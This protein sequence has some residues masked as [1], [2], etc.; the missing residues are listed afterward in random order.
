MPGIP[1]IAQVKSVAQMTA[2]G[3]GFNRVVRE[4]NV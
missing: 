4:G 1:A 2:L 3:G